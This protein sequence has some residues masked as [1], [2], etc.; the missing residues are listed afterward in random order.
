MG[1]LSQKFVIFLKKMLFEIKKYPFL[2]KFTHSGVI[3][4]SYLHFMDVELTKILNKN[5]CQT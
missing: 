4:K 2:K 1:I 5:C 3:T